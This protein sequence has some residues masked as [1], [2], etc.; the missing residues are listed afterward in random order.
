M[1]FSV[2]FRWPS[3][4]RMPLAIVAGSSMICAHALRV[5]PFSHGLGIHG[6]INPSVSD[7]RLSLHPQTELYCYSHGYVRQIAAFAGSPDRYSV[8]LV[9]GC[10]VR[11]LQPSFRSFVPMWL[12]YR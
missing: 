3:M 1:L 9:T 5:K 2:C 8:S 12:A 11:A 6:Y 7:D 10:R 4:P